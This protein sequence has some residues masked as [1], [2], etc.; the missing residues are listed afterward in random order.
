LI[1]RL[2]P[3]D[4][5]AALSWPLW[6]LP[7]VFLA[8]T[9]V[10]IAWY[11]VIRPA[12]MLIRGGRRQFGRI[13]RSAVPGSGRERGGCGSARYLPPAASIWGRTYVDVEDDIVRGWGGL[14]GGNRVGHHGL[15]SVT[16]RTGVKSPRPLTT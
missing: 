16:A 6:A 8:W 11:Q 5:F 10:G 13:Q 2:I 12:S 15:R 7:Y 3:N 1:P 14:P 9:A 4:V